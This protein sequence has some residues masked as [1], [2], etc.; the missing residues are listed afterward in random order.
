MRRHARCA[1]CRNSGAPLPMCRARRPTR[2]G[3]A[4]RPRTT[5]S[6]RRCEAH[7]ASQAPSGPRTW[8]RRSRS[9]SRPRRCRIRPTG[10]RPSEALKALQAEWKTIG[11]VSR[12]REKA[13]WERF[14][15]ACDRFFTRRH[16]DLAE[17]KTT[18]NENLA[19]KEALCEKAEALA[20]STDWDK[21]A[22]EI[23]QL[24]AEWKTIGPVKKSRSEAIWQRFRAA[25]DKFFTGTRSV[26]TRRAPSG[27]RR[28][29]RSAP[30]S[31]PLAPRPRAANRRRICSPRR[32]RSVR[33][34]SRRLP[35]R[36]V[37]PER[38]RALDQR[39]ALAFG[40]VIN[41]WPA[42]F[43]GSDMDPESN[44]KRM[45]TLV[46]KVEALAASLAGACGAG[47]RGRVAD[48]Q[49]RRDAEGGAGRQHHRR[50]GR[51][52]QPRCG[53]PRK[54]CARRRRS[55][56]GSAWCRKMRGVSWPTGSSARPGRSAIA[57]ARG[58][59]SRRAADLYR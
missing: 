27:S 31:K 45:E 57:R 10:S 40:T 46:G 54:N 49:A 11:P 55:S 18:W 59:S 15:G 8:R 52:R 7:F 3:A 24:Q 47:R 50:Q 53:P 22:G 35:S 56:R 20:E 2:C 30:N 25:C 28:A 16:Q 19:R 6:G 58:A 29:K 21:T 41:R 13:I 37:D 38:A 51:R 17:R 39:F 48:H 34:G 5:R 4:S 12:G 42:V 32:V 14:R 9:A 33:A 36:G 43:G 23:R 44:R 26:T 1:N